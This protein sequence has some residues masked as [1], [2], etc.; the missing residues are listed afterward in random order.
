M[1]MYPPSTDFPHEGVDPME[2]HKLF[3]FSNF[4]KIILLFLNQATG[5]REHAILLAVRITEG[6]HVTYTFGG[7]ASPATRRRIRVYQ[8]EGGVV[9]KKNEKTSL[10]GFRDPAECT[11]HDENMKSQSLL[12]SLCCN[13]NVTNALPI[14]HS[15]MKLSPL[16]GINGICVQPPERR[17]AT[18]IVANN[19]NEC[20]SVW[21]Q[22]NGDAVFRV[23]SAL[24]KQSA[25]L[26]GND[27]VK[28]LGRSISVSYPLSSSETSSGN[29]ETA[30]E[31]SDPAAVCSQRQRSEPSEQGA[32]W[33]SASTFQIPL[34]PG[35]S[36]EKILEEFE[37]TKE[38]LLA[39]ID[40]SN[41]GA[42]DDDGDIFRSGIKF[43]RASNIT[44]Q[45]PTET[46][47]ISRA[48]S[49]DT[50]VVK[51]T[52]ELLLN[53]NV[54]LQKVD[55]IVENMTADERFSSVTDV[56]LFCGSQ[57]A[58]QTFTSGTVLSNGLNLHGPNGNSAASSFCSMI[59]NGVHGAGS[60]AR[61]QS[62]SAMSQSATSAASQSSPRSMNS[63][64][65]PMQFEDSQMK[66]CNSLP[67]IGL[68]SYADIFASNM[69]YEPPVVIIPP[70]KRAKAVL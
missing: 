5:H 25:S 56:S 64:Y 16:N 57:W 69:K 17:N 51:R 54:S 52:K 49:A 30:L 1:E 7:G 60:E 62:P 59:L 66:S 55:S 26:A 23:S 47:S 44:T 48:Y 19:A 65:I 39:S 9:P 2:C 38:E 4:M 22:T 15:T 10:F 50:A 46:I 67:P 18:F 37:I 61:V 63:L 53:S 42:M 8:R 32:G 40:S 41:N 12:E 11:V 45:G 35:D 27:M 33:L 6:R 20:V 34:M 3:V 24:S 28:V 68:G 58:S 21:E 29:T 14:M 31:N 70:K 36:L 43:V 13:N